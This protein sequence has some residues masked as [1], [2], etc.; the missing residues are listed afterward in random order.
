M[1]IYKLVLIIYYVGLKCCQVF[2][3]NQVLNKTQHLKVISMAEIA[4][5]FPTPGLFLIL[6]ETPNCN[7]VG[8]HLAGTLPQ[9]TTGHLQTSQNL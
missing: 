4:I 3:I 8:N 6:T 2:R 9:K 5:Y 1:P 7:W